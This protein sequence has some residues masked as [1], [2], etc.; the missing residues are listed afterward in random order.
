MA[1][2]ITLHDDPHHGVEILLPWYVTGRLDADEH[3]RVEDHLAACADCQAAASV[4]RRLAVQIAALPVDAEHG[5][6]R[7]RDRLD[8]RPPR[9]RSQAG[10]LRAFIFAWRA[11]PPWLG[12]ALAAEAAIVGSLGLIAL[13]MS[14]PVYHALSA[15]PAARPGNVVV[16]FRPETPE[17]DLRAALLA[18]H[19]RLVDGPTASDA[20]VLNVPDAE[21]ASILNGL[22]ARAD[23]VLAE[24]INAG[25]PS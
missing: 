23:V 20:Y 25:R 11:R 6:A 4:E 7:M 12:W 9:R 15:S 24:P 17:R 21:R 18:N 2:I 3:A 16:I 5:W 22:R 14:Q 8:A 19:A 13:P 10:P 1:D